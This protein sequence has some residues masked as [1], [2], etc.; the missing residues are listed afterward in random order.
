V[1][2][3]LADLA[4]SASDGLEQSCEQCERPFE[5]TRADAKF[6]SAACRQRAYR[7]RRRGLATIPRPAPTP[8]DSVAAEYLPA[9]TKE[10]LI[11]QLVA[12]VAHEPHEVGLSDLRSYAL[13]LS[14]VELRRLARRR[15]WAH[16]QPGTKTKQMLREFALSAIRTRLC[17]EQE[18][19]A[20]GAA[21]WAHAYHELEAI[22]ARLVEKG[23]W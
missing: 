1:S 8:S 17:R 6:C 18:Q 16:A 20:T 2:D 3:L 12:E 5:P 15:P 23:I 19:P 11:E 9:R 7:E 10:E 14:E 22:R 13:E 21:Q 4:S